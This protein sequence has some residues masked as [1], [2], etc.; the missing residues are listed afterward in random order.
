M[1]CINCK[2]QTG[3]LINESCP[4]CARDQSINNLSIKK[5]IIFWKDNQRLGSIPLHSINWN[6]INRSMTY[7]IIQT[8]VTGTTH[9]EV[10]SI[11]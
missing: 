2:N 10:L 9:I 1:K 4:D 3:I 6:R 8:D 11:K 5:W 7:N